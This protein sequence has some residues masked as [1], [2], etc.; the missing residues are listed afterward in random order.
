MVPSGKR[1]SLVVAVHPVVAIS[2]R[3]AA[4]I[5]RGLMVQDSVKQR[6]I[7]V[8]GKTKADCGGAGVG[9]VVPEPV[10]RAQVQRCVAPAS[11]SHHA[12]A[13]IASVRF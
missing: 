6:L 2:R 11:A 13:A 10:R 5:W 4:I 9:L 8:L 12:S 1:I 3:K 7:K